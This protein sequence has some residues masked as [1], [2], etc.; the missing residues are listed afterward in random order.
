MKLIE[1]GILPAI[2]LESRAQD[3][4]YLKKRGITQLVKLTDQIG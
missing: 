1:R 4:S 3:A 2:V